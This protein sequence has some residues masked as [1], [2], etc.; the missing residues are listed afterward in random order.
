MN[1]YEHQSLRQHDSRKVPNRLLSDW[2][3]C[4]D[5]AYWR[6]RKSAVLYNIERIIHTNNRRFDSAIQSLSLMQDK[7]VGFR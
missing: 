4:L 3:F 1:Q 2:K 7:G 6:Y 5:E